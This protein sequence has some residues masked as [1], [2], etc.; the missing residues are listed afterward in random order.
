MIPLAG[1]IF[2]NCMNGISLAAERLASE[3][4]QGKLML[5]YELVKS[6]YFLKKKI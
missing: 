4:K 2:A 5:F 6:S 1:M 3:L